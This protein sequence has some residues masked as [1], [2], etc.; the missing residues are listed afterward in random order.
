MALWLTS[1]MRVRA[2]GSFGC[3]CQTVS[4]WLATAGPGVN[5][6]MARATRRTA[7]TEAALSALQHHRIG[8]P[9]ASHLI[10]PDQADP[11]MLPNLSEGVRQIILKECP[12]SPLSSTRFSMRFRSR[13]NSLVDPRSN[14]E[15]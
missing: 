7:A 6:S 3:G 15:D 2:A 11:P 1:Y 10:P 5:S 4:D 13:T 14:P 12:R 8:S 9:S